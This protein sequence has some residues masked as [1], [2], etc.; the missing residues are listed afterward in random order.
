M[1]FIVLDLRLTSPAYLLRNKL[2]GFTCIPWVRKLRVL[3]LIGKTSIFFESSQVYCVAPDESTDRKATMRK[4]H[5]TQV[6]KLWFYYVF[7]RITI[8][9]GI[10]VKWFLKVYWLLPLSTD[11]SFA[12]NR[13]FFCWAPMTLFLSTDEYLGQSINSISQ[14]SLFLIATDSFSLHQLKL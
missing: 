12:E 14:R 11:D 6:E 8:S 5:E 13:R 7:V 2:Q 10:A 3:N 1:F 4:P 9:H